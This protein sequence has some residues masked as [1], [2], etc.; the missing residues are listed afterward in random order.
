MQKLLRALLASLFVKYFIGYEG[1]LGAN[2]PNHSYPLPLIFGIEVLASAFLMVAI[3][4]LV[5][6]RGLRGFGGMMIGS[7]VGLDIFFLSF[8]SGASM[9][10]A[11]SLA[12]TLLSGIT[13]D[14]WIYW[15]ATFIGTSYIALLFRG[16]FI[17][18]IK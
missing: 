12:P 4:I 11:R 14:L 18:N 17:K 10:P 16:K 15:S 6:A 5:Y 1:N 9:N 2:V 7:I 8:I 3:C 13:N